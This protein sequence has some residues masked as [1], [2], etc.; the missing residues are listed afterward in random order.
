M[1]AILFDTRLCLSALLVFT[2][3]YFSPLIKV[4]HMKEFLLVIA[5]LL[6]LACTSATIAQVVNPQTPVAPAC[7]ADAVRGV[8]IPTPNHTGFFTSKETITSHLKE[9]SDAG[10]NTV[11]VVMWNQGRT[12]YKSQVLKD[13][14]G[15]EI[16]ERMAGR[17]PLQEVIAAAKPLN[18]KVYAWFEFGFATDYNNGKGREILEKK[19]QWAAQK[20]D[21]SQ[22]INNKIRWMDAFNPEVQSFMTS[23]LLEVVNGYDVAG[24]QGDD[25][26]PAFPAMG[27]YNPATQAK[28]TKQF[29]KPPPANHKD[30][31]W[32]QWR[33]DQL[34]DF[35]AGLYHTLKKAKPSTTVSMA[36]SV[37][38]WVRDEFLQDWPTWLKR[39]IVD[40]VTPQLYRK[41]IAAYE[42]VIQPM[43]RE[44]VA[45]DKRHV[46]FPGLLLRLSDGYRVSEALIEDMVKANR[47]EG[48]CGEVYFFNEGVRDN[49]ALFK[50]L[51]K[52][53]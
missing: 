53:N 6:A 42:R 39:G 25:R 26:L 13:L 20:H 33:A 21:G 31:Q 7:A 10:I 48:I 15:V 37:W 27:G 16:D 43:A 47:R 40:Q 32:I 41:D 17:D 22:L 4:L 18:I 52:A 8:W 46:V 51:Y 9:L 2:T 36:P 35:M 34:T 30:P 1:G 45:V 14:I 28:Y 38:P 19:P 44:Q 3:L 29:N 5:S 50:R 23:L 24:V 11:Y 49:L 12:F